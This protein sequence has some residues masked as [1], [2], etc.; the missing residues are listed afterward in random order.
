MKRSAKNIGARTKVIDRVSMIVIVR[1]AS[2]TSAVSV[3][4]ILLYLRHT[5][6]RLFS[7]AFATYISRDL[8]IIVRIAGQN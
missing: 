6:E 5:G 3:F 4:I 2:S 7:L 1:A 8:A